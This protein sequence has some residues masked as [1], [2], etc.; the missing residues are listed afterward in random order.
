MS[1][2]P[3]LGCSASP[4]RALGRQNGEKEVTG[5]QCRGPST[6]AV[7]GTHRLSAVTGACVPVGCLAPPL[8]LPA[9]R[10]TT[11]TLADWWQ[12]THRYV[13]ADSPFPWTAPAQLSLACGPPLLDFPGC[14][15]LADA[16][17]RFQAQ[18]NG[19]SSSVVRQAWNLQWLHRWHGLRVRHGNRVFG[20][21][22]KMDQ[23]WTHCLLFLFSLFIAVTHTADNFFV[24]I[25]ARHPWAQLYSCTLTHLSTLCSGFT[26]S[27]RKRERAQ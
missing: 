22:V 16:S 26:K 19:C 6:G 11:P 18:A 10:T 23:K 24:V 27:H 2:P 17:C 5:V 3:W 15:H 14:S 12:C 21:S 9:K 4:F 13:S 8:W 25:L 1:R 7:A 20:T